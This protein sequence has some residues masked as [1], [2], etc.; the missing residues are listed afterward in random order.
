MLN[1]LH[2][3]WSTASTKCAA[4]HDESSLQPMSTNACVFNNRSSTTQPRSK[5]KRAHVHI[6][7]SVWF[8]SSTV[9]IRITSSKNIDIQVYISKYVFSITSL[10]LQTLIE[11]KYMFLCSQWKMCLVREAIS[12]NI[13]YSVPKPMKKYWIPWTINCFIEKCFSRSSD[14]NAYLRAEQDESAELQNNYQKW[15][16]S[17]IKP[18]SSARLTA[19]PGFIATKVALLLAIKHV[20]LTWHIWQIKVFSCTVKKNVNLNRWCSKR[21]SSTFLFLL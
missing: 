8:V 19:W 17:A 18:P 21:P 6:E 1:R 4:D 20:W 3:S 5:S 12:R 11:T 9:Q 10:I 2:V 14:T 13:I 7:A 15:A 16:Q